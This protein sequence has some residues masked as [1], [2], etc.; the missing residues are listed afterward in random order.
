M[1]ICEDCMFRETCAYV[2]QRNFCK[3]YRSINP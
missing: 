2:D 3:G 1:S